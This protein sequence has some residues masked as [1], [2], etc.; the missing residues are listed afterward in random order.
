MYAFFSSFA[1][2]QMNFSMS[3]WSAFRITIFAARRVLPPDLITPA[4]ASKPFMKESGPEARPPPESTAS[5]SRSAERFEPVPEPHLNSM[6]SVLAR[7]RIDSSESFTE[8]MKHAE[9]CGRITP[10]SSLATR[11][12]CLVVNPAVA[13]RLLHA[14]VE[15]DRRVEA[16]LLRQH[17]VRQLEPEIL[18]VRVGLE[19]AVL[20]APVR[21]GVDHALDQLRDAGLALGRP[22][23]AVEILAG[24]DIGGRLRPVDRDL[25]IALLED[26]GAFIISNGG[27]AGLPLDIVVRSLPGLQARREV[28]RERNPGPG[29]GGGFGL[30]LFHFRTQ[31]DGELAHVIALLGIPN[32]LSPP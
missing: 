3:G 11:S 16:R 4:N 22:E 25:D 12:G 13:A 31:I 15:P 21:D 1:L 32:G 27:G 10:D 17:Q 14:D 26:D 9:H 5:S 30:Q 29:F 24:D 8:T 2:H 20:L 23:F 19:V 7:S 28:A 6:P 18:A